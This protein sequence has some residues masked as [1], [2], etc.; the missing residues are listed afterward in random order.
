MVKRQ[1]KLR[2]K[3]FLTITKKREKRIGNNRI[4]DYAIRLPVDYKGGKRE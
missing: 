1:Y 3:K 2:P 4:E